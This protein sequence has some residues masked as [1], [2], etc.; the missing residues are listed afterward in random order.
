MAY[1]TD[2]CPFR[3]ATYPNFDPNQIH[4]PAAILCTGTCSWFID[5]YGCAVPILAKKELGIIKPK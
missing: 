1:S 3:L 5:G 2:I 4:P